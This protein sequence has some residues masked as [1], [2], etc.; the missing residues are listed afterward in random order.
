MRSAGFS[1]SAQA[2]LPAGEQWR[3]A[4][5]LVRRLEPTDVAHLPLAVVVQVGDTMLS[6]KVE[7]AAEFRVIVDETVQ[8]YEG[9][10]GVLVDVVDVFGVGCVG[11]QHGVAAVPRAERLP[12]GDCVRKTFGV[13]PNSLGD[14]GA[15]SASHGW[16]SHRRL[17]VLNPL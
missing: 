13:V 6:G 15:Q 17:R 9:D 16:P 3:S 12:V 5:S 14:D 10:A 4:A 7:T 2:L 8:T 11:E 1:R